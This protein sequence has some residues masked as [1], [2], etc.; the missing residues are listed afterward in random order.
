MD[1][2]N[3]L[4][5]ET[6]KGTRSRERPMSD[7]GPILLKQSPHL[8]TLVTV[9][10]PLYFLLSRYCPKVLLTI[11]QCMRTGS[12]RSNILPPCH[13]HLHFI[14]QKYK[15]TSKLCSAFRTHYTVHHFG[16]N[17]L[18]FSCLSGV[19]VPPVSVLSDVSI[20]RIPQ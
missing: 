12:E 18:L 17:L 6:A 19:G 9:A 3:G 1:I 5:L 13:N 16:S 8:P 14:P 15:P 2:G 20:L 4:T 10:A 7:Q 11:L